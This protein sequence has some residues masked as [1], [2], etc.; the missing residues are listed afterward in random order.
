MGVKGALTNMSDADQ[1]WFREAWLNG[2]KTQTMATRFGVSCPSISQHGK[3]LGLPPRRRGSAR[4]EDTLSRAELQAFRDAWKN[5][6]SAARIA[7][8]YGVA[9]LTILKAVA[10]LGLTRRVRID[11]PAEPPRPKAV[12]T[13]PPEI[14]KTQGRYAD[15]VAYAKSH[16]L[17][18][19]QA[20]Q[21][22]HRARAG[23]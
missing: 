16:G 7:E 22:Y 19:T 23:A 17:T 13:E 4:F 14:L 20:M 15:L 9:H 5:G 8:R 18:M 6:E 3:R 11:A 12:K 1:T 10:R 2:T 21:R